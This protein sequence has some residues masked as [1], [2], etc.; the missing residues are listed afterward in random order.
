MTAASPPLDDAL[1]PVLCSICVRGGSKGVPSK[2]LRDLRGKP[3]FLHSVDQARASGRF[4]AI[5][6]SSDDPAIL[7]V[8]RDAGVDVVVTRPD[9]LATDTAPKLPVIR[10]CAEQA[11]AV[12]GLRFGAFVDLDATSPL[13]LPQDIGG[14]LDLLTSS[15]CGVVITGMPARRSPYFNLVEA[16]PDG[17]VALAK[18]PAQPITRRQDAP[19]CF[20]MNA[21][22]YAWSAA[23]FWAG[24]EIF[25]PTTR[26]FEMPEDRSVDIDSPLDW[27]LVDL[28]MA[29]RER[30]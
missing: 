19:R 12:T 3:L 26:L 29:E 13:R 27:T 10:H 8:A 25:T 16:Q 22:I 6:V 4:A 2:N 14:V 7:A 5:A 11:E 28:L 21:S 17:S 20:D 9:A 15:G 23:S 1:T 18:R 30:E 24:P